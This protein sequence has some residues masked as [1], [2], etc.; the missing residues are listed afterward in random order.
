VAL[1]GT[2]GTLRDDLYA[3]RVAGAANISVSILTLTGGIPMFGS[4]TS[5]STHIAP[6][7]AVLKKPLNGLSGARTQM[8]AIITSIIIVLAIFFLL[9]FLYFLPKVCR[10]P[11]SLH[12]TNRPS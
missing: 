1:G 6:I 8:A 11:S 10:V 3:H 5:R 9:P 4:I 7:T 2:L 12:G